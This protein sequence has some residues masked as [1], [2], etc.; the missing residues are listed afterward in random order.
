MNVLLIDDD[1]ALR[2]A[3]ADTFAIAGIA[4]ESHADP[5]IALRRIDPD[6]AGVVVT[7]IRMPGMDGHAVF[8][9]VHAADPELPVLLMTGHGD[10]PMAVAA[11][12]RGAFDFIAKPFATDHLVASVRRA[13][14]TR[15]LVLENRRLRAELP[16]AEEDFPLIGTTAA[17]AGLR[18]AIRQLA[19]VEVDVLIEG[20]TGTG[21]ELVAR[22]LHRQ[23]R[24]RA[25][26]FVAIDCAAL[27]DHQADETLFGG[28]LQQGRIGDADRGTLFLDE[29]DS[30]S[31][32]LQG[33]LLRVIEERELP[34]VGGG[35][36]RSIDLRIVAA[37]KGD[38]AQACTRGR[39]RE[40]LLYRLET[41]RVRIPPLR[42]RRADV[43][44]L[45]RHFLQDAAERFGRPVPDLTAPVE[46][47]LMTDP[48]RG[49]VRAL[50]NFA[51]QTVLALPPTGGEADR[52]PLAEQV[53]RFETAVIVEALARAAGDVTSAAQA[54][55]I[56]RRSLYDRLQ[57]YGLDASEHR[58]PG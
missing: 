53:A 17:M 3:I 44:L 37:A 21:K 11:M 9:A 36:P 2:A 19:Q 13:L 25:R 28:R 24:R 48:W 54:L 43:P 20:E 26:E 45:F 10:I 34:A 6:F 38:L 41:V 32:T 7:D 23:S 31:A 52:V 35:S 27:P 14:E 40:D 51:V 12:E 42:E 57:R 50:R 33:K 58:R 30:M 47:R 29:I 18:A 5:R 39:F 56:S 15:R 22:M 1:D 8:D 49:N 4:V 16:V 46:A 55:S